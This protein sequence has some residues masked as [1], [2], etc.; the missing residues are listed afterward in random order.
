[1]TGD[2]RAGATISLQRTDSGL[3]LACQRTFDDSKGPSF[4]L[5]MSDTKLREM[6]SRVPNILSPFRVQVG[7]PEIKLSPKRASEA[8][9]RLEN[10]AWAIMD[11]LR[12]GSGLST[13]EFVKSIRD[14]LQ[15]LFVE[16]D[17]SGAEPPVVSLEAT[18]TDELTWLLPL[19]LFPVAGDPAKPNVPVAQAVRPYLGFRAV[20]IRCQR[21]GPRVLARDSTGRLPIRTFSYRGDDLRGVKRQMK[22]FRDRSSGI[23]VVLDWPDPPNLREPWDNLAGQLL[24]SEQIVHFCCHYD[25]QG[26]T[27]PPEPRLEFGG[28]GPISF[29]LHQLRGAMARLDPPPRGQGDSTG[30]EYPFVFLNACQ[31]AEGASTGDSLFHLLRERSYQDIVCSETLLPDGVAGEFAIQLYKALL[32]GAP[33]GKAVLQA[34]LTLVNSELRNP[35]GILYTYHGN[36][37]LQ[38]APPPTV[39]L[40]LD[41]GGAPGSARPG[42]WQRF[43]RA[44]ST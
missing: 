2:V 20:I 25:P 14:Y 7:D 23:N 11:L 10:A 43:R 38:I 26:N 1:M 12:V 37:S 40:K 33:F 34:R 21:A 36:P 24:R 22:F 9:A 18:T 5:T 27:A 41:E 6:R 35:A 44:L 3:I 42:L 39:G 4:G 16:A 28:I 8:V 15:P 19:E 13:R 30:S 29:H 32:T 31:T 17:D